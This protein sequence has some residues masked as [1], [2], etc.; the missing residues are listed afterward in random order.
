MSD[1]RPVRAVESPQ[2]PPPIAPN[3]SLANDESP[4]PPVGVD[5][6]PVVGVADDEPPPDTDEG[7]ALG[8]VVEEY[9]LRPEVLVEGLLLCRPELLVELPETVV[10]LGVADD[11]DEPPPV[12]G[13]APLPREPPPRN[14]EKAES[15]R[16][17]S[18]RTETGAVELLDCPDW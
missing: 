13:V 3:I 15:E 10:V 8:V 16:S 17:E 9:L 1:E 18:P 7:V 11:D 12:V 4:A 14:E 5:S 2:K 6:I